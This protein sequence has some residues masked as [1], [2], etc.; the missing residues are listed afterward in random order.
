MQGRHARQVQSKHLQASSN[1]CGVARARAH[2]FHDTRYP[3]RLEQASLC[4]VYGA[5]VVL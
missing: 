1:R 5:V 2:V 4:V 3:P